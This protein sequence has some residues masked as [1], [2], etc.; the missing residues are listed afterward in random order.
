M[1]VVSSVSG[2]Y[3]ICFEILLYEGASKTGGHRS[4]WSLWAVVQHTIFGRGRRAAASGKPKGG[5]MRWDIP[6]AI[7]PELRR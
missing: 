4:V 3:W 2:G 1:L 7:Q 5:N 6:V